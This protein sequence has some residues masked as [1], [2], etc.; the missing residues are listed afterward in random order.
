LEWSKI[1]NH[2]TYQGAS[3]GFALPIG[4]ALNWSA[5][6]EDN[7]ASSNSIFVSLI[8]L[9]AIAYYN[10]GQGD[11]TD[12]D[13][14]ISTSP[15]ITFA[16]VLSPGM[17]YIRGCKSSPISFLLGLQYMPRLRE[18]TGATNNVIGTADAIQLKLGILVDVPLFSL[19][20]KHQK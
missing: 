20:M 5:G 14:S 13:I 9:G 15:D 4:V 2:N 10:L 18:I 7:K 16:N 6:D 3:L 8:D 12:D 19:M 17:A 1:D 11:D